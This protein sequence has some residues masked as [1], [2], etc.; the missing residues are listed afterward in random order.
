M[1][2]LMVTGAAAALVLAGCGS[3]DGVDEADTTAPAEQSATAQPSDEATSD[4]SEEPTE[5]PSQDQTGDETDQET[6]GDLGQIERVVSNDGAL[7]MDVPSNWI[8]LSAD[9]PDAFVIARGSE[10]ERSSLFVQTMGGFDEAPTQDELLDQLKT[11]TG[12]DDIT[13]VGDVEINGLE[14]F[15]YEIEAEDFSARLVYLDINGTGY[16]ITA[17]TPK[18][19][20][21]SL[22]TFVESVRAE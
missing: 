13:L 14:G 19:E 21:T 3:V 12:F 9:L 22:D 16:E 15:E 5:D 1:K 6:S 17:N 11:S 2:K 7:S 20:V 18:G 4:A 8:D 10:N